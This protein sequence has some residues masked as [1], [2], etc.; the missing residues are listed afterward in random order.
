YRL[1]HF[2]ELLANLSKLITKLEQSLVETD[3]PDLHLI[4][5]SALSIQGQT[6]KRVRQ[7]SETDTSFQNAISEFKKWT[8]QVDPSPEVYCDYGVALYHVG[9]IAEAIEIFAIGAEKG[10]LNAEAYRFYGTSLSLLE[11]NP[12]LAEKQ[13]RESLKINP[14][15]PLSYQ[16]LAE[17]LEKQGKLEEAVDSYR[18]AAAQMFSNEMLDQARTTVAHALEINPDDAELLAMKGYTLVIEGRY[19]AAL[20][21]LDESLRHAPDV[22]WTLGTK[23]QVLALLSR[24]TEALESLYRAIK[25]NASEPWF[26]FVLGAVLSSLGRYEEAL[27]PLDK[28]IE[29]APDDAQ[30][31]LL[32]GSVLHDLKRNESARELLYRAV[33]LDPMVGPAFETLG[34][35]LFELGQ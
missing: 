34:K 22:A 8:L 11:K 19:E 4:Y 26:F 29:L 12:A 28:A 20:Q 3:A 16:A 33:E 9:Q 13:F 10:S 27:Q 25:L 1:G 32:K 21:A 24:E 23:G 7:D 35:T 14:N 30:G 18:K 6:L 15:D 17:N 2:K 31:L 5:A